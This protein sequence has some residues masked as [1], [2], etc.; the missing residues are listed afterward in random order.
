MNRSAGTGL[1]VGF[2]N[3]AISRIWCD[4][5]LHFASGMLMLWEPVFNVQGCCNNR[6]IGRWQSSRSLWVVFDTVVRMPNCEC[7]ESHFIFQVWVKG[8]VLLELKAARRMSAKAWLLK[9]QDGRLLF[10]VLVV[11]ILPLPSHAQT[12]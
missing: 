1:G 10:L 3:L 11:L 9:V 12:H 4:V 6:G 7:L 8:G 2:T 5:L